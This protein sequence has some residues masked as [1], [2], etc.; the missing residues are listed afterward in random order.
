VSHELPLEQAPKAYDQ[1][2]NRV[3]GWTKVLLHPAA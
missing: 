2:D 1:F 3:E